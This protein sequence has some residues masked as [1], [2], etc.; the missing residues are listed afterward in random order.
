MQHWHQLLQ[1]D[2]AG[3]ANLSVVA[4]SLD[5]GHTGGKQVVPL[6]THAI[7]TDHDTPMC[8]SWGGEGT[9]DQAAAAVQDGEHSK[10]G[11]QNEAGS[12]CLS[13]LLLADK[14]TYPPGVLLHLLKDRATCTANDWHL[15]VLLLVR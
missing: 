3:L 7:A 6:A 5:H 9:A 11:A 15:L 12:C 8:D 4:T 14:R 10:L 1:I 2:E 13:D